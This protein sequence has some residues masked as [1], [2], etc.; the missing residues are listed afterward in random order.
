MLA[1]KM[2]ESSSKYRANSVLFDGTADYLRISNDLTGMPDGKA[3]T[4]SCWFD[5]KGGDGADM[6]FFHKKNTAEAFRLQIQRVATTNLIRV[7]ARNSAN[8]TILDFDTAAAFVAAGGWKHLLIAWDLGTAGRRHIFITDVEDTTQTTFTD[9]TIDYT[10]GDGGVGIGAK[11]DGSDKF[12]GEIA[13]MWFNDT[14]LDITTAAERRKFIN[15]DLKPVDLGADGSLPLSAVPVVFL[16]GP[17]VNWHTN[18]GGGGGFTENGA[19]TDGSS[20]PSD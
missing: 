14:W 12:N 4:F 3:G 5:L 15:A 1:T 8:S 18:K 9:D 10:T 7:S 13:D 17:T 2:R 16:S 20:S 19:L 6:R 11:E